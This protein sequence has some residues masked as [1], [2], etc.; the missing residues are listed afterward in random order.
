MKLYY[1][2]LVVL[3]TFH[4][5]YSNALEFLPVDTPFEYKFNLPQNTYHKYCKNI[6]S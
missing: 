2:F 4:N 5:I 1:F 3:F 6:N